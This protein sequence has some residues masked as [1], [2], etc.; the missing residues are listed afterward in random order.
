[1]TKNAAI[2][3]KQPAFSNS[4]RSVIFKKSLFNHSTEKFSWLVLVEE[5]RDIAGEQGGGKLGPRCYIRELGGVGLRCSLSPNQRLRGFGIIA[6]AG[7]G[8][9]QKGKASCRLNLGWR[10][11]GERLEHCLESQLVA[12]MRL[13][14][15]RSQRSRHFHSLRLVQKT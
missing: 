2:G 6:V 1:M 9:F 15:M 4:A 7:A 11:T 14:Q 12:S 8:F 3:K 5:D 13:D 10:P